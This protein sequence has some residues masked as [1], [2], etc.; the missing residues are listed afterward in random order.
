MP[1]TPAPEPLTLTCYGNNSKAALRALLTAMRRRG[2]QDRGA[3]LAIVNHLSESPRP[4]AV[5][6][7]ARKVPAEFLEANQLRRSDVEQFLGD[8]TVVRRR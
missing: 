2:W 1:A 8:A 6:S 5:K 7:L 3:A 4:V